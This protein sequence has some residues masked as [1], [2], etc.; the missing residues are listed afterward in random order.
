MFKKARRGKIFNYANHFHKTLMQTYKRPI[1]TVY[2]CH[3]SS[4]WKMQLT[5]QTTWK[6]VTHIYSQISYL[7]VRRAIFRS[8]NNG[9]LSKSTGSGHFKKKQKNGLGLVGKHGWQ[10]NH[11]LKM[12]RF[13][14][15]W[16]GQDIRHNFQTTSLTYHTLNQEYV[17][18]S[19]FI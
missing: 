17:L 15:K 3:Q 9:T 10:S 7:H 14:S 4:I 6:W 12:E 18:T 8:L 5:I 16:C 13:A 2:Q 11:S 19:N 1:R